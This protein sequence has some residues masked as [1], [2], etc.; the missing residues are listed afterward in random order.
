MPKVS[1]LMPVYNHA[2]YLEES[3][4]SVLNQ[5]YPDYEVVVVDDGSTDTT[6]KKLKALAAK[7][8][9]LRVLSREHAG[10][11][12]ALNAGIEACRGDY[13][14]RM[15]ADDRM[16][17][18]RLALQA[19][20]LDQNPEV[21]V[22]SS[23]VAG[24]PAGG[25]AEGFRIYIEWLNTLVTDADIRREIFV[26]SPV[27]HPSVM[28]RKSILLDI[29]GYQDNGWAEDYDLWLRLYLKGVRFEKLSEVLVEWREYPARLTRVDSRYS[30]ENFLRAK[31][32]Y[33]ALGPLKGRDAVIVWGAGMMGKRLSKHLLRNG[34]PLTV[35]VDIDPKKI[36]STRRGKPIIAPDDL[37]AWW[38]KYQNPAL[39]AAVGARGARKLIRERLG[40]LGLREGV[41]W[42]GAA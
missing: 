37:M 1:V 32:H 25:V 15:D 30:V 26:E 5:S 9:Q 40:Q 27:C 2:E 10:I 39:L 41:D 8:P 4:A 42:W 12:S 21:A 35:F 18:D 28:L 22:V 34:T 6:P 29:G 13:I 33:L 3:L 14:A 20:Y 23:L 36:G 31:A 16:H 7:N 17:P 11:I 24:F 19:E 38:G